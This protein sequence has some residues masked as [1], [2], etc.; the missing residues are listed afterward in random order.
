MVDARSM[1]PPPPPPP[2]A[3]FV[4][5]SGRPNQQAGAVHPR[6]FC[7]RELRG[8][9][10]S[11]SED[12]AP[13]RP[14]LNVLNLSVLAAAHV[15][16]LVAIGYMIFVH[17]DGRTLL[18]MVGMM[19]AIGLAV[20]GGYHRLFA[21]RTHRAA[22]P[23]QA[24]YLLFGAAAV[25]NS[26]LR[27]AADHRV[28]HAHTDTERDPYSVNKGFWWAHVGW[29]LVDNGRSAEPDADL[30][31]NR[32][33]ALQHRYYVILALI[34]GALLPAAIASLWGD[35][36]GG[37]LVAGFLR[38]VLQWHATFSINSFA[39]LIGHRPYGTSTSARDSMITALIS[40]GEGYHSFHHRFQ[41]DY[42]NG[43][44]WW[45]FDPTKWFVWTMSRVGLASDLRRTPMEAI[46]RAREEAAAR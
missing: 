18:L 25:Q 15:L 27:W 30:R 28:H 34:V 37:L 42:R 39:H 11:R 41:A 17:F 6:P 40:F 22:K 31:E 38:L 20:T 13:P 10:T 46:R 2:T 44:H 21:H 4:L 43:V 33:V 3:E 23:L 26:A 36:L 7:H 35:A 8:N 24:A 45:Q 12:L 29:V 5:A 1:S 32:L 19:T 9:P 16:A 14:R